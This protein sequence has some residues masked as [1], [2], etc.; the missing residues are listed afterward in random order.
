MSTVAILLILNIGRLAA[1]GFERPFIIGNTIVVEFSDVISTF[2]YRV[3]LQSARFNVATAVGLFQSVV[4]MFLL[5]TANRIVE[6]Y[7]DQQGIW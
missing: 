4:G 2:V 1:I 7:S 5:L 3:G 6:K